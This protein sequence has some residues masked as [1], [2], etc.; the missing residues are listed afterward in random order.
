MLMAFKDFEYSERGG[1]PTHP[2]NVV[3]DLPLLHSLPGPTAK[4]FTPEFQ[5]Q[6]RFKASVNIVKAAVRINRVLRAT[7]GN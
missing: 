6:S 7:N 5:P 1:F 3:Y 2:M 4:H